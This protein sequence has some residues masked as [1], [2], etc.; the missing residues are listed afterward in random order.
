MEIGDGRMYSIGELARR[1][2]MPV[3]TI[4]F[5]SDEGIVPESGRSSSGHRRYDDRARAQL[6]L[7]ATLRQLGLGLDTVRAIL[8]N[9]TTVAEVAQVHARALEAEIKGLKLRRAVLLAVAGQELDKEAMRMVSDLA[10]L[11]A[12][13]RKRLVDE[14]IS[15][16]FGGVE[17]KS[18]IGERMREVTS[19]LPE[20][21]S[22]EQV[23]AWVEVARMVQDPAF[24]ERVRE[25]AEAGARETEPF[26]REA[27]KDFA[28]RVA[29][30]ATP[31]VERGVDPSSPEAADILDR[32]V[33]DRGKRAGVAEQLATFADGRV[34]RYWHL[35][36][37]INGW[38][39][40]PSAF[41]S[42][43]WV[44]EALKAH[45]D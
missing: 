30:H 1:T 33:A 10:G 26:D 5:W 13:E 3:R 6:E 40:F 19:S 12:A 24:R 45:S 37:I 44:I 34:D 9:R 17:D 27:G 22:V 36:G 7:V 11:S 39:P 20:D 41:R 16:T 4:R 28:A 18:G 23:N 29:E 21:P 32:I 14:F 31:A 38:P 42:Y 8:E 35:V 43:E 15:E 25:M 2:G